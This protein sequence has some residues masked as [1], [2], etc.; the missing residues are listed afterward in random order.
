[1][2]IA[3]NYVC[4]MNNFKINIILA[5]LS[6]KEIYM[7][8]KIF[9]VL[10]LLWMCFIFY[11]SA[12]NGVASAAGS[13]RIDRILAAIPFF[14]NFNIE[15]LDFIVRKT[16]HFA[17][18]T[19]L[20]FLSANSFSGDNIEAKAFCLSVAYA[21]SDEIHQYFVPGRRCMTRDVLIDSTGALVGIL[22]FFLCKT[23]YNKCKKQH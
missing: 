7:K 18:Y 15:L 2:I 9:K 12:Q 17:E 8:N 23:I 22:I 6:R 1:M 20:G 14:S 3:Y 11:M 5:N 16:A 10:T 19:A 4:I 21:A 13:G